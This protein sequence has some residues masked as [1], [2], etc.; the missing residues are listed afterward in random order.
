MSDNLTDV[1]SPSIITSAT[2]NVHPRL[3][4]AKRAICFIWPFARDAVMSMKSIRV[5]KLG[6]ITADKHWN[7]YYDPEFVED[8]SEEF[9]ATTLMREIL[10]LLHRYPKRCGV[11]LGES[12]SEDKVET[13]RDSSLATANFLLDKQYE[14]LHYEKAAKMSWSVLSDPTN[15]TLGLDNIPRSVEQTFRLLYKEPDHGGDKEENY[16]ENIPSNSNQDSRGGAGS[17]GESSGDPDSSQQPNIPKGQGRGV[18]GQGSK[19][20]RG[21]GNTERSDNESEF[22][23]EQCSPNDGRSDE[24]DQGRS[25]GN[26]SGNGSLRVSA[27][28]ELEW[29]GQPI[30]QGSS[31]HGAVRP[32]EVSAPEESGVGLTEEEI[33]AVINNV[34]AKIHDQG[35]GGGS[36]KGWADKT[37]K[38]KED[39]RKVIIRKVRK[40]VEQIYG[41]G[42]RTYRR[43]N[44][45]FSQAP[46]IMGA[47]IESIPRIT[48]CLDTSGSMSEEDYGC[49]LDIINKVIKS[50]RSREGINIV[51]GD[52]NAKAM[53][54]S[55]RKINKLKLEGG[56]GTDVGV[57]LKEAYEMSEKP[58]HIMLA[59]TDGYTPWPESKDEINCP[60]IAAITCSGSLSAYPVPDWIETIVLE[61]R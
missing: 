30:D 3:S 29:D 49:A 2:E 23:D 61:G 39:P 52:T 54:V 41:V 13:I 43:P 16:S 36:W 27:S 38:V 55:A 28:G 10:F 40:R 20:G 1:L 14:D 4:R 11:I 50:F 24:S 15:L 25:D 53:M 58:P 18:A 57:L 32:W 60:V 26:G 45:R 51:V 6:G 37:L 17:H 8:C 34:A 12:P 35:E 56:G 19:A 33:Q 22:G 7:I 46:F 31:A 42:D 5:N 47:N 21:N 48:I 9:I 44:R 59:V